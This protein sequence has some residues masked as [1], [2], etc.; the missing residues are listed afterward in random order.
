MAVK[1]PVAV[2]LGL[3]VIA[4]SASAL[5]QLDDLK[6]ACSFVASPQEARLVNATAFLVPAGAVH[7]DAGGTYHIDNAPLTYLPNNPHP[8][9]SDSRMYSE[10]AVSGG[11]TGVLI[12]PDL[13]LTAAH[14]NPLDPT[15]W[16]VVF[17]DSQVTAG[18][19]GCSNFTWT[20]IPAND[21]YVPASTSTVANFYVGPTD[22]RYDY[23][24]FQL[25]RSV[26]GRDPVK[27]RRSGSPKIG[28]VAVSPGYPQNT[29]EKVSSAGVFAG[30]YPQT[31]PPFYVGDYEYANNLNGFPGSSGSPVYDV[32]DETIDALVKGSLTVGWTANLD[33]GGCLYAYD[34]GALSPTNG[35]LVDIESGIPRYEILVKPLVDVLHKSALGAPT[36]QPVTIYSISPASSGGNLIFLN[37]ISGPSGAANTTPV[38][39]LSPSPGIY[40]VPA[41]GMTLNFNADTSAITQCGAW[42][43]VENVLDI[44]RN[45]N[46]YIRH[47]FEV[48]LVEINAEP[49]DDW[50]I[51]DF[52]PSYPA[53]RTYTVKNVRPSPTTIEVYAGGDLPS[54]V[55][56]INGGGL[57]TATLGPAGSP[58]DTATF[59]V[60]ISS[61]INAVTSPNTDYNLF[62]DFANT[63]YQ[64]S[65]QDVQQRN[66]HFRRNERKVISAQS[67]TLLTSPSQGQ[68]FGPA[69]RFDF[70]LTGATSYCVTDVNLD[71]GMPTGIASG[72]TSEVPTLQITLT[73]P[74][75]QTG[76]IWDRNAFPGG[77]YGITDTISGITMPML[78]LDDQTSVPLGPAH[79]NHFIGAQVPGHWYVDVRSAGGAIDIIGP[80]RIDI[81]GNTCTSK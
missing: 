54:S 43:Y 79:L 74:S 25:N 4:S 37:S 67:S 42:D 75:G 29:A 63:N 52:G 62:I 6:D 46:N 49:Q 78:H 14:A 51:E 55:V 70:D 56:T 34:N 80:N 44:S 2:A 11:R 36:D 8:I 81:S 26:I 48:G 23:A 71:I 3:S 45:E 38:V 57:T 59:V 73:A 39:S 1:V 17:R 68:T 15:Q 64:C 22:N 65:A 30:L 27:I 18:A 10:P 76:V 60:G 19:T 7:L 24:V 9:C 40:T 66:I 20:G 32:S 53:T 69:A 16:V 50:I 31:L 41:G 61:S 35:P 72:P 13:I 33:E 28:D 58:T 77:A 12:A 5:D 47:R 21:V